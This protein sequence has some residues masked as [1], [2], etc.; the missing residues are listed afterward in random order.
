MV[1][2]KKKEYFHIICIKLEESIMITNA[3]EIPK[4]CDSS[5]DEHFHQIPNTIKLIVYAN[6]K[7][8]ISGNLRNKF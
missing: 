6:Q 2:R 3:D 8:V 4:L 7:D 5:D 1:A